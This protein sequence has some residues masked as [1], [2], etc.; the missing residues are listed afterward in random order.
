[1]F[2]LMM[3][4]LNT[5]DFKEMQKLEHLLVLVFISFKVLSIIK[6]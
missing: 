3:I 1:M 2:I 6:K 5:K 4:Y